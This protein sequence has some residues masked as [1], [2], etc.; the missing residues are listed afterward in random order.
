MNTDFTAPGKAKINFIDYMTEQS[1]Y[2]DEKGSKDYA[3]S[4]LNS[5]YHL[6]NI[7]VNPFC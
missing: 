7:E 4:V 5:I 3:Q 6:K 2:Y 1:Q